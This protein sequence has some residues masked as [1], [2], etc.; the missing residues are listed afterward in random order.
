MR[1]CLTAAAAVVWG[2]AVLVFIVAPLW[3]GF[4]VDAGLIINALAAAL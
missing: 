4:D 2:T 3:F 1:Y